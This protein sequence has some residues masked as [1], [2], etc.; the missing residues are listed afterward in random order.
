[1]SAP[2]A[3]QSPSSFAV[4]LGFSGQ[5]RALQDAQKEQ[6]DRIAELEREN[7]Q[8]KSS[9]PDFKDLLARIDALEQHNI[10]L[11]ARRREAVSQLLTLQPLHQEA[12]NAFQI[13]SHDIEADDLEGLLP[14]YANSVTTALNHQQRALGQLRSNGAGTTACPTPMY[15]GMP[16]AQFVMRPP[17]VHSPFPMAY[18]EAGYCRAHR[19]PYW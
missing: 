12:G 10:H 14:V 6:G 13:R 15:N 18:D 17:M 8:L 1:M 4:P 7:A 2:P 5:L 3:P 11:A 16:P 9:Q 19:V